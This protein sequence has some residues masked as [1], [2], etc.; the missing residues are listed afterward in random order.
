[1]LVIVLV[2]SYVLSYIV[3]LK[4]HALNYIVL[5]KSYT[6]NYIVLLK[7]YTLQ[8]FFCVSGDCTRVYNI[9]VTIIYLRV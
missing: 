7:S 3:L 2:K 4:S 1:M 5:L 8:L 6:L 9:V